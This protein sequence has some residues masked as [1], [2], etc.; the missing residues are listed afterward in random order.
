MRLISC[1]VESYGTIRKKDIIF[2]RELTQ[3]M[4]NNGTGKTTLASFLKAMFYGLP[5][6]SVK[7]KKFDDRQHFCPFGAS[8]FGGNLTFEM[9]GAVYRIERSFDKKSETKDT[10][11][12]FKNDNITNELGNNIG[13][14]IFGIDE[15]SFSR[16][17]FF[18]TN[19]NDLKSTAA[20]N[21]KLNNFSLVRENENSYEETV[22]I[23][24]NASKKLMP[25]R[26]T[27]GIIPNLHEKIKTL[28]KEIDN[29][30]SIN[31]GLEE[32][33][34]RR[35]Q[36]LKDISENEEMLKNAQNKAIVSEKY[37]TYKDLC[38]QASGIETKINEINTL[39]PNGFPTEDEYSN[40]YELERKDL[41]LSSKIENLEDNV[42]AL[43]EEI[44]K[45]AAKITQNETQLE[46]LPINEKKP[47]IPFALC[48]L[49]AFLFIIAIFLAVMVGALQGAILGFL[50]IIL[51]CIG[52]PK[53]I[54]DRKIKR[55]KAR[56]WEKY[57][58]MVKERQIENKKAHEEAVAKYNEKIKEKELAVED[59]N[60]NQLLISEFLSRFSIEKE[61][62]RESELMMQRLNEMISMHKSH[63]MKADRY[64]KD[65]ELDEECAVIE[66]PNRD[67]LRRIQN[68]LRRALAEVDRQI[69]QDEMETEHLEEKK[70]ELIILEEKIKE[71]KDKLEML[72]RTKNYLKDAN[73][74]L[75]NKYVLPIKNSFL[76]YFEQ[77]FEMSSDRIAI[78]SDFNVMFDENGAYRSDKHLSAGQRSIWALCYRLALI[79]NM[80]KKEKPFI[81][82]DDPF[83]HLDEQHMKKMVDI[84]KKLAKE[85]QVIYFSCHDSRSLES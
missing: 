9:D 71:S 62:V 64:K 14:S 15:E 13:M 27:N 42:K 39:Y 36:L 85:R 17:I 78:D 57:N 45:I 75:Q 5:S 35:K 6:Y 74:S 61:K 60:N 63:K 2:S 38:A 80:Y 3:I 25:L 51:L 8:N 84:M 7:S 20:I 10:V 58:E 56:E 48:F 24:D 40:F 41:L 16:T 28:Y 77:L 83:V 37:K 82:L 33:Y 49:A 70:S 44:E 19:D 69:L 1:Y 32:K 29:L 11:N 12:V 34:F 30:E 26:G 53:I 52:I 4:E 31:E 76:K 46:L 79:E 66:M 23:I 68:D 73:M 21:S 72:E 59:Y 50:S 55:E 67:E 54:A 43:K 18:N 65:N 47:V 81:I 22:E